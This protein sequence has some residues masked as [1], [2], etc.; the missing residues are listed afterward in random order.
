MDGEDTK[1]EA[2]FLVGDYINL[3]HMV[4]SSSGMEK[5]FVEK[6]CPLE[7]VE[8]KD[9]HIV[10]IDKT[11]NKTEIKKDQTFDYD[12]NGKKFEIIYK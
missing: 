8:V 6:H 7:I 3:D 12:F 4:V 5:D 2:S 9:S 11:G 1:S 10:V